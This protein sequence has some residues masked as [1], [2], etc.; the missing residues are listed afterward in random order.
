M[1]APAGPEPENPWANVLPHVDECI[2]HLR[3]DEQRAIRMR[4][5]EERSYADIAVALGKSD[6]AG[7]KQTVRAMERLCLLLR[8]RSRAWRR[9]PR[10]G[11]SVRRA[12]CR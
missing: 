4:Y 8:R 12:R 7:K 1:N 5:L 3:A 6:E 9:P 2:Q 11:S 10:L